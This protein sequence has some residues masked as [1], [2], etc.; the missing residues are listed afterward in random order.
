MKSICVIPARGGSKR[1]PRK[2]IKIFHGKPL[3]AWSI[4][5]AKSSGLFENVYI[6]TDDEEIASVAKR[7]GAI[8]PFLRP[9]HLSNDFAGDKEV[10]DHF[11]KWMKENMVEADILCYLYATAPFVTDKTLKGCQQLL[12][13]SGAVSAHTVTTYAY[14]VLRSL[15]KDEQG[16]LT[17]MWNEYASSRS[18]DLPE[19]LHDAGQC[20][21]FN[22][23]K[24]GQGNTRVGYEMPRIYCQDIDTLEDFEIA[25]KLFSIVMPDS[26][27]KQK[28]V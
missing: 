4:E 1:I 25:E 12:L 23:S 5:V 21:F 13:D 9:E 17:F 8:I 6:S 3:I 7:Y 10:R 24:Y 16:L 18:Q 14:P 15:K 26:F 11:I 2:N 20:Y 27:L 19:L 22:L 28:P